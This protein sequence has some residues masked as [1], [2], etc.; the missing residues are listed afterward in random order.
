MS[1]GYPEAESKVLST[2]PLHHRRETRVKRTEQ[3]NGS[4]GV[5]LTK[6]MGVVTDFAAFKKGCVK[7][8]PSI[9]VLF[10]VRGVRPLAIR[11]STCALTL[12]IRFISSYRF[13]DFGYG[14]QAAGNVSEG[15]V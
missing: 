6:A 12:T 4:E 1:N 11:I 15:Q 5:F 3:I 8:P 10:Q 2:Q 13:Q 14:P 9:V 7:G